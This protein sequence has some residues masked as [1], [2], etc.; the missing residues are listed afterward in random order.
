MRTDVVVSGQPV[1]AVVLSDLQ[2]S[3][4]QHPVTSIRACIRS[5]DYGR[6]NIT[7][8]FLKEGESSVTVTRGKNSLRRKCEVIFLNKLDDYHKEQLIAGE[9]CDFVYISCTVVGNKTQYSE[10]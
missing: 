5:C 4:L 10:M 2:P 3:Q 1:L 7:K 6:L 9:Y 8:D